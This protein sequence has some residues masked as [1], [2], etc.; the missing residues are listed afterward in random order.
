[1]TH[2][3]FNS[4]S[5]CANSNLFVSVNKKKKKNSL[6]K[7][8]KTCSTNE[9]RERKE[10]KKHVKLI[11]LDNYIQQIRAKTIKLKNCANLQWGSSVC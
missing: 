8:N 6:V 3:T 7:Q 5:T 1:M 9:K 10:R 2:L 4:A 11:K